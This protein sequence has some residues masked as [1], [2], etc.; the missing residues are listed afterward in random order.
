M[1]RF[2]VALILL[3]CVLN[4][5]AENTQHEESD[6]PITP[7]EGGAPIS[8]EVVPKQFTFTGPRSHLQLVVTGHYANN[9][10]ADLTRVAKITLA[11]ASIAESA[12]RG[13][14]KP[15]ADGQTVATV[16][17][18]GHTA[19]VSLV[20]EDMNSKEPVSFHYEALPALSKAGC[21]TGGCHGAPHGKGDFRLSLWG[22][23]PGLDQETII[24]EEFGR[25][26][27]LI[28]PEQSL[29]LTKPRNEVAHEGGQRF[30][31]GDIEHDLLVKW[32]QSGCVVE[33]EPK[34]C[35]GIRI[36]PGEDRTLKRPHHVQQIKVEAEFEDGTVK[37]VTHIAVFESSDEKVCK[38][39]RN[40]LAVGLARGEAAV[41]VRYLEYIDS[42][43]LSFVEDVPELTW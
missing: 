23:D 15:I 28:E 6:L 8:I 17:I 9:E 36:T 43:I 10:I 26:I 34:R 18:G 41:I 30:R 25:R 2:Y 7:I 14:I 20:V 42:T 19:P 31:K 4:G 33:E 3:A 22:F 16:S 5:R 21:G 35:V 32:I 12:A 40:G 38:V 27:N 24:H 29:F 39:S 11:D 37:D 1:S 13:V